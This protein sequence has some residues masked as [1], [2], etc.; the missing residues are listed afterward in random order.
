MKK[1]LVASV[2]VFVA[3]ALMDWLIHGVILG[4]SY[5]ATPALWRPMQEMKMGVL[6]LAVFLNALSF[7]AIYAFFV[8]KKSLATGLK[9]GLWF[10]F[11]T[12]VAM[13]YGTYSV[14]PIPYV[15]ALVWFLGHLA[16]A[17]VGGLIAGALIK[18][19]G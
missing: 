14:M 7:C 15:M 3:W 6:Y 8:G 12:G 13:G 1:T 4:S 2:V 18:G 17:A 19:Q 9:F 11:G 5:A 16:E 10:G